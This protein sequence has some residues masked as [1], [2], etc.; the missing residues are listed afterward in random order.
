MGALALGQRVAQMELHLHAPLAL[1]LQGLVEGGGGQV[2]GAV[3]AGGGA[4]LPH[5]GGLGG[6]GCGESEGKAE[7]EK[8]GDQSRHRG[9]S[10]AGAGSDS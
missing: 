5:H 3:G 10:F 6:R 2:D 9:V 8:E 4:H 7:T 1:L